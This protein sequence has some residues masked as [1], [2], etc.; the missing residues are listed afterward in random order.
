MNNKE[1]KKA[2]AKQYREQNKERIK[3]WNKKNREKK[4]LLKFYGVVLEP[5]VGDEI[6]LDISNPTRY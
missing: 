1:A 6:I 2:Y 3:E 5:F 4:L